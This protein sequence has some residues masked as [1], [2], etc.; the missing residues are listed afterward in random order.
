MEEASLVQASEGSQATPRSK[1]SLGSG[2][3]WCLWIS[4]VRGKGKEKARCQE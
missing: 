1:V 4:R 3:P 2:G